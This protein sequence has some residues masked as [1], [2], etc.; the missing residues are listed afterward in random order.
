MPQV[1]KIKIFLASPSDVPKERNYL[2]KVIDETN[3]TIAA[4]KGVMLEAICS[5]KNAFPGYG[6]DGQAVLNLQIGKMQEYALFVGI[7][8]NRIGTPT[9]RAESGTV[10]EFERAVKSLQKKGQPEIWFYFRQSAAQLNTEEA[11][12]QRRK[13]LAFKKK[14][15]GK[16]L[17]REYSA[18][19]NFRDQFREHILLWLSKRESKTLQPSVIASK[20]SKLS[21]TVNNTSK[22]STTKV[23]SRRKSNSSSTQK[24]T[25]LKSSSTVKKQLPTRSSSTTRSRKSVSSSGAWVLLDDKFFLTESVDTQADQSLILH[26]SSADPTQEAALRNLHPEQHYYK[27]Q[28]SYAYQNEAAIMQVKSV[29]PKSIRG[30][31]TFVLTLKPYSQAQGNSMMEMNFNGYSTDQ[32]AELRARFL[33]LNEL[34][35]P[36]QN[37]NDY[38]MLNSF[39][40]GYD[41][42]VKVEQCVFLNLWT[43][44][45]ND[46]QLFL[47]HARLAAIYHLKMSSTVEHILEL[48]LTLLKDN[49]LSVQFRGQRKQAYSNQE[50]AII[51]VK[52]NCDLNI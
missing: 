34:L 46:P 31:T 30:K 47:T 44:L 27:K 48:K 20:N 14:I 45:K 11:L 51:E 6:Q 22:S 26:I 41:N 36:S 49:I 10:E 29:L 9:P 2:V 40:K 43:R 15:Q 16:A 28:I 39:I 7:M 50:P 13:V 23:A 38:S 35:S 37:K 24:S 25:Q 5:E 3:R 4:S 18:P 1:E 12:E 21:P 52:G 17:I 42:S 33:L 19:A 8:W 32:I